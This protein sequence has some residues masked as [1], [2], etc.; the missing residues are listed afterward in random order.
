[1]Q[2]INGHTFTRRGSDQCRDAA[3][4]LESYLAVINPGQ[5]PPLDSFFETL[6]TMNGAGR[7]S[8]ENRDGG[9]NGS[10]KAN[11]TVIER[12]KSSLLKR[13][14]YVSCYAPGNPPPSIIA[15]EERLEA[16]GRILAELNIGR[17]ALKRRSEEFGINDGV[18][19]KIISTLRDT[20]SAAQDEVGFLKACYGIQRQKH[21]ERDA[22]NGVSKR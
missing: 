14:Q 16:I 5:R 22:A 11:K 21:R 9:A 15:A 8:V 12:E 4:W 10:F 6:Q 18:F 1:M 13:L 20:I 7:R 2:P 17:Q 19:R 3:S